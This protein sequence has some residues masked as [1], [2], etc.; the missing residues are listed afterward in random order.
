MRISRAPEYRNG[1]GSP[2]ILILVLLAVLIVG[3]VVLY[4]FLGSNVV[5]PA[6]ADPAPAIQSP[7]LQP[8]GR[9]Q[10]QPT[11][12]PP[13]PAAPGAGEPAPQPYQAP[14]V[15]YG[16]LISEGF[17][18]LELLTGRVRVYYTFQVDTSTTS[19]NIVLFFAVYDPTGLAISRSVAVQG[20]SQNDL[21]SNAQVTVYYPDAPPTVVSFDRASGI[22]AASQ[23]Y[24]SRPHGPGI[25]SPQVGIDLIEQDLLLKNDAQT[26]RAEMQ[27]DPTGFSNLTGYQVTEEN[28]G[29]VDS[30]L[31]EI[32]AIIDQLESRRPR[33]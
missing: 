22:L 2:I 27:L 7:P 1:S 6:P 29:T 11:L 31:A 23:Y 4:I 24:T 19:Q 14:E 9:V 16:E 10:P 26:I 13:T 5:S 20:Y 3:G 18:D 25:F 28:P 21:I 17:V 8:A 12:A 33:S 32:Q 15:I 30:A